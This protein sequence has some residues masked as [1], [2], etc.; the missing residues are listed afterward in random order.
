M[1]NVR[2]IIEKHNHQL[3][4]IR[5][6]P[7]ITTFCVVFAFTIMIGVDIK[8]TFPYNATSLSLI[9]KTVCHLKCFVGSVSITKIIMTL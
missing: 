3:A 8:N 4:L 5:S 6:S 9:Y 2:F 7:F 1:N